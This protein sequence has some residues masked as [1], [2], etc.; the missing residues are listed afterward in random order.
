MRLDLMPTS[1]PNHF[2]KVPYPNTISFDVRPQQMNLGV[3]CV[4]LRPQMVMLLARNAWGTGPDLNYLWGP[5]RHF[6]SGR[7]YCSWTKLVILIIITGYSGKNHQGTL[8]NEIYYTYVLEGKGHTQ[9]HTAK[10]WGRRKRE[11]DFRSWALSLLGS[12]V[13]CLGFC[14]FTLYGQI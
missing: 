13:G 10:S 2:P 9:S 1:D 8:R 5:Y 14:W 7:Q 3:F 11:R 12:K 4:G 6:P